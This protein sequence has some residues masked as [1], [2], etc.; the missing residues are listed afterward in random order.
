M[1]NVTW[2]SINLLKIITIFKNWCI[3]P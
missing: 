2:L 1:L 3:K